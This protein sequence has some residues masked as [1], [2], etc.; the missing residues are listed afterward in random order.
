MASCHDNLVSEPLAI[1]SDAERVLHVTVSHLVYPVD[2][3]LLHQLFD[4]YGAEKKIEVRQMGTYVEA[5]IPFQTRAAAE[6]AWNL[7]G[8]A[9]YDGCCWLDIQWEQPPNNSTTPV[10]SLSTI[11]TEWKEDIKE[12]RPVL[13]DFGVIKPASKSHRKPNAEETP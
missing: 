11:I 1:A 9:I 13:Q 12:L 7:N 2:E 6:H 3:Y 10:T 4:G 8:R 5:S